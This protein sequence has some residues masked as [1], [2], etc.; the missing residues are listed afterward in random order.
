[1]LFMIAAALSF[2]ACNDN[3]P[4]NNTESNA[5]NAFTPEATKE[6]LMSVAQ[7][8]LG[9]FNTKDQEEAIK[10][11]DGLYEKYEVDTTGELI[12]G[13]PVEKLKDERLTH[14]LGNEPLYCCNIH[15]NCDLG[16]EVKSP[17]LVLRAGHTDIAGLFTV[18][19]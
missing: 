9:K 2:A 13:T 16:P 6:K 11:A 10:L 5:T 18:K 8:L 3:K 17:E 14:I 4:D 12:P 1:M 19:E 7:Q 15:L